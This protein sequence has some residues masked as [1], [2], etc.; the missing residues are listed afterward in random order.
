M[1]ATSLNAG[2]AVTNTSVDF[3]GHIGPL[4]HVF[5]EWFIRP[6][7]VWPARTEYTQMWKKPKHREAG[8]TCFDVPCILETRSSTP[9]LSTLKSVFGF[10]TDTTAERKSNYVYCA[11][12]NSAG[13]C[14]THWS[15]SRCPPSCSPPG[16]RWRMRLWDYD[17]FDV[18]CFRLERTSECFL[19]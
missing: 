13:I 14:V 17:K 11:K 6:S 16:W 18:G 1:N 19:L 2:A 3:V 8:T 7:P 9:S 10:P 4:Q 12:I 15:A 5:L